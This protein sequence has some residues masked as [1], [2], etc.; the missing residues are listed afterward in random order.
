MKDFAK[1]DTFWIEAFFYLLFEDGRIAIV[2][3]CDLSICLCSTSFCGRFVARFFVVQP[4]IDWNVLGCGKKAKPGLCPS[5]LELINFVLEH[6]PKL[7]GINSHARSVCLSD[8]GEPLPAYFNHLKRSP[9]DTKEI[10]DMFRGCAKFCII[11]FDVF[12]MQHS[13]FRA[14]SVAR[15]LLY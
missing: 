12:G 2:F 7:I 1:A 13:D 11:L 9:T 5:D 10:D 14:V 6:V 4:F 15:P 3:V 8:C